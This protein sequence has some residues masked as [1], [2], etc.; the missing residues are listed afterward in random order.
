M[1]D[2][3]RPQQDPFPILAMAVSYDSHWLA[4]L[5]PQRVLLWNLWEQKWGDSIPVDMVGHRAEL[6]FFSDEKPGMIPSLIIVRRNGVM[7][8]VTFDE[9]EVSEYVVCKT[10][11]VCAVPMHEKCK[12]PQATIQRAMADRHNSFRQSAAITAV[13]SDSIPKKLHPPSYKA[14]GCVDLGGAEISHP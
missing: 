5:S 11:L 10:P 4:L 7:L 14:R 2:P 3:D 8:E 12:S 9:E 6:L 1:S 13:Y